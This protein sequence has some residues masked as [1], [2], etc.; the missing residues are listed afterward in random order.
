LL[1]GREKEKEKKEKKSKNLRT[2]TEIFPTP[3][4]AGEKKERKDPA[5]VN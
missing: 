4:W 2:D 1:A 3:F 5:N